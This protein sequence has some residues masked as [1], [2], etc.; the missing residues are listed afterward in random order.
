M[1]E[2]LLSTL[3][4]MFLALPPPA[5]SLPATRVEAAPEPP[6][7]LTLEDALGLAR[8]ANVKLPAAAAE[9]EIAREKLR[10]ARAERWLKVA[11]EGDFIDAPSGSYDPILTNLG[12]ERLQVTAKQP[13]YDGGEK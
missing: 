2:F 11:I 1:V 7:A 13:L 5:A 10:E 4:V 6:A 3:P 9:T 12:E 8:A